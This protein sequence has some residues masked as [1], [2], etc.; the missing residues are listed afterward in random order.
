FKDGRVLWASIG[1]DGKSIVFER[2]FK[3]WQCDT[4]SSAAAEVAITLRGAPAGAGTNR[5]P[6]S[7]FGGLALSPDGKKIAV[8]A[9]G[10]VWAASAKDGGEAARVTRSVAAESAVVWSPDSRKVAYL[11]DRSGNANVFVY[12]FGTQAERQLTSQALNDASPE[13][14]PD[15]KQ[16]AFVRDRRELRVVPVAGGEEKVL[17]SGAIS[18]GVAWS[19][20]G[21]WVAYSPAGE[22][23]FRNIYVVPAAGGVAKPISFLGNV[24][25][26]NPEWSPDGKY[27]LFTTAQR[28]EGGQVARVELTPRTPKF[29]EDQFRDLF[30]EEPKKPEAPKAEAA[31]AEAAKPDAAKPEAKKPAV[32]I[33]FDGIK[34]RVTLLS[35]GLDSGAP[36]ISPDGK[37][38]LISADVGGQQNLYLWPLDELATTPPVA[39]Q[40]TSTPGGK[41]NPQWSP[42]SKEVW[43][44]ENGRVTSI[45]IDSRQAKTLSLS[46]ELDVPFDAEKV[47]VFRQA[48][49]IMRDNFYDEKF[50]GADW[51]AVKGRFEPQVAGA[52]TPDEMRRLISLMLG[53]LNASHLGISAPGGGQPT[54]PVGKLGLKFDRAEYEQTG[55]LKITE[56]LKLGPADVAKVQA[57][58]YLAA[59]DGTAIDRRTNLDDLLRGKVGKRVELK[60]G[61]KVAP[62]RPVS[63]M[64]EGNLR[65]RQWVEARRAYVEKESGGKLGYVHMRDMG[66]VSLK[67]LYVDLDT[68]N[69]TKQGVVIDVRNNNG[70]FVNAYA[71]DVFTRQSY[72]RMEQRGMPQGPARAILGQRALELPT[73]LVTNQFSLS[74]AEDFTEGYRTLKLGKVV[75]EPTAG[76]II[77]TGAASLLDGSILRTPGTKVFDHQG[78]VMELNPRPVDVAVQRPVGE[79]YTE[80]DVQLDTAVRELLKQ[81]AAPRQ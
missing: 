27:L 8:T 70:G 43:F 26:G 63:L 14:S 60:I 9:R 47:A 12:D 15:G 35:I 3:V 80:K 78:K 55:K 49:G 13:F 1:Y 44:V 40:L 81:I 38:L 62:V 28:T 67:Q 25:S 5:V 56:V 75:G 48:W 66:D 21:Q 77:Y 42:D 46:A 7:S 65:Y 6:L 39:R 79:T 36:A 34:Q 29:K 51:N 64:E 74:D 19:G 57:G 22:R 17:A 10:E 52:K 2:D 4:K 37:W 76:W 58:E 71:L 53:E 41:A 54:A 11:S 72:L 59:V 68:E 24:F 16:I 30:K 32:E 20:D 31:K 73:I 33:A 23:S 50:H 45:N 69:Q 18:G 61:D